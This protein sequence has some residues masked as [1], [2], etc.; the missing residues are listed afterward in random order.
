MMC[1]LARVLALALAALLGTDARAQSIIHVQAGAPAPG[2]GSPGSPYPTIQ[3]GLAHP[4]IAPGDTVL[5]GAGTYPERFRIVDGVQV[6][7]VQGPLLTLIVATP[8]GGSVVNGSFPTAGIRTLLR[9]FTVEGNGLTS[10]VRSLPGEYVDVER[11]ILRGHDIALDS[12]FD[13][14]VTNCTL[15]DNRVGLSHGQGA[16]T[17]AVNVI[18][19]GNVID[20]LDSG[21]PLLGIAHCTFGGDPRFVAPPQDVH[22]RSDSPAIDAGLDGTLDPDGSRADRGALPFD[23]SWPTGRA[24]CP[25][26]AHS[27]GGIGRITARGSTSL[28]A[29]SLDLVADRLPA[30][31]FALLATGTAFASVPLGQGTLCVGGSALRSV[32]AS[33]GTGSV[34]FPAA[35]GGLGAGPGTSLHFQVWF[36]DPV[37]GGFGLTSGVAVEFSP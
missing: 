30:G 31:Q 3:A 13:L 17:T 19:V 5:V 22:L 34:V 33:T 21:S 7:S 12:R 9:G 16:W 35:P 11:C 37:P 4:G 23:P 6:R 29:Q 36:R 18:S 15:V 24:T 32:P 26:F 2:D 1:S 8:G 14:Q 27:G 20:F 28:A 25:G 10:G